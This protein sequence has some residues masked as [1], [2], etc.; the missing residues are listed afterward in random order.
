MVW[1]EADRGKNGWICCEGCHL[2]SI[3]WSIS[4][5]SQMEMRLSNNNM[6]QRK[7]DTI[8][9]VFQ[10]LSLI[11][12]IYNGVDQNNIL[13]YL[14]PSHSNRKRPSITP[15]VTPST[16]NM[17]TRFK[18]TPNHLPASKQ[19]PLIPRYDLH[20]MSHLA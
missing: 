19:A 5:F 9:N 20:I 17:S 18:V 10:V 11:K 4:G 3:A 15:W 12:W 13:L 14:A 16:I 8:K 1:F 2:N 6:R 7:A